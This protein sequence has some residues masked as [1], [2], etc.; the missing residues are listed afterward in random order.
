MRHIILLGGLLLTSMLAAP[1]FAGSWYNSLHANDSTVAW[2]A[3]GH[4]LTLHSDTAGG[5]AVTKIRPDTSWGLQRGDEIVAVD[6]HQVRHIGELVG[7]LKAATP[8]A[9]TLRVRRADVERQIT[10]AAADYM[11]LVPP[12]PTT[13]TTPPT[14]PTGY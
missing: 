14:P 3:S 12:T 10:V 2:S 9:V 5:I 7:Q 11:H 8:A 1:A 13:P 6:G 4:A